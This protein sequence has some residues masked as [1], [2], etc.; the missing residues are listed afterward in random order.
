MI[1]TDDRP[2]IS[3]L[4]RAADYLSGDGTDADH[5]LVSSE[6]LIKAA[7]VLLE[8]AKSALA[9]EAARGIYGMTDAKEDRWAMERAHQD[10]AAALAKVRL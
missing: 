7:P 8:I 5:L 3:E 1:S 10:L 6:R 4:Q 9:Q 2:S